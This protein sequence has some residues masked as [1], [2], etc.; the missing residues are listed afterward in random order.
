MP[1][2][3]LTESHRRR[4]EDLHNAGNANRAMGRWMGRSPTTIG[5][6]WKCRRQN[7]VYDRQTAQPPA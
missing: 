3:P 4:M 6:E 2:P 7:G 5:R 1:Y